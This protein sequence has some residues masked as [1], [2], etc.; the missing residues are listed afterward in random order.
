MLAL[1]AGGLPPPAGVRAAR[2]HNLMRR[3]VLQPKPVSLYAAPLNSRACNPLLRN[4]LRALVV[5]VNGLQ[6]RGFVTH[7]ATTS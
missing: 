7:C 5:I 6:S 1:P 2:A 3:N 4:R